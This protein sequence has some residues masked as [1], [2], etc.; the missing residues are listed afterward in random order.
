[1]LMRIVGA[2]VFAAG[3]ILALKILG[4]AAVGLFGLI[5]LLAKVLLVVGLW[6]WGL[7]WLKA[8]T[9]LAKVAGVVLLVG[10]AALALPVLG[11]VVAETVGLIVLL[12]KAAIAAVLIYAGWRW[13]HC[14]SLRPG[15]H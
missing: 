14:R 9:T 1:M 13:L 4:A 12:I 10:G 15:H 7:H 5:F 3:V 8:P 6:Y 11:A 2:V